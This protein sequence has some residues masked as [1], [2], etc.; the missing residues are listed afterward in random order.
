LPAIG[1]HLRGDVFGQAVG[2]AAGP[3]AWSTLATPAIWAAACGGGAGVVAGD[4][5]V[6]VAAAGHSAR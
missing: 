4:Q 3:S 5:H 6:H 2:Q 1:Q